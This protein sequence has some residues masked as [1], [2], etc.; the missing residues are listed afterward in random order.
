MLK[1]FQEDIYGKENAIQNHQLASIYF[2]KITLQ[3]IKQYQ[4][5]Y[6]IE[7]RKKAIQKIT[8]TYQKLIPYI[9]TTQGDPKVPGTPYIYSGKR[10]SIHLSVPYIQDSCSDIPWEVSTF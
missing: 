6:L 7:Q 9:S 10:H 5:N 1:I 3:W 4:N 8:D 2:I